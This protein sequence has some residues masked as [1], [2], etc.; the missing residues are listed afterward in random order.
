MIKAIIFDMDGT[1]YQFRGGGTSFFETG[2]FE[3][4]K[5]SGIRFLIEKLRV[6][7][8][9][10]EAIWLRIKKEFDNDISIGVET[11]FGINRYEYFDTVWNIDASKYV[12]ENAAL[13]PVLNNLAAKKVLLTNAPRVWAKAVLKQIN[14]LDIF[15]NLFFGEG[16]IRKPGQGAYLQI[17][18]SLGVEPSEMLMVGNDEDEDLRTASKLGI[19]TILIGKDSEVA[20]LCIASIMEL[21]TAISE[22]SEGE[23]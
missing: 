19:K 10:A 2:V 13:R 20:D 21:P 18:K 7:K 6:S 9:D 22:L 1:L 15:D 3:E 11:E 5:R 12:E 4:V 17:A 23:Q 8:R 14:V 16:D